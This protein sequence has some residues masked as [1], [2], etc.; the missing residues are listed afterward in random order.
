[1]LEGKTFQ[2]LAQSP[3]VEGIYP[4]NKDSVRVA[5]KPEFDNDLD[6]SKVCKSAHEARMFVQ[7]A[8]KSEPLK[9]GYRWVVNLMSG[10]RIQES[11]D[12]PYT[13]SVA[14]E[15]YWSS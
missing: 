4:Y 2:K 7:G 9:E 8:R 13:C 12:T 3:K 6:T 1:M 5:L 15:T 14:S 10:K 11:I